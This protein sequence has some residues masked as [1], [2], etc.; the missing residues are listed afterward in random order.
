MAT[1]EFFHDGGD[2]KVTEAM[3]EAYN[4]DGFVIVRNLLNKT[5]VAKVREAVEGN[6]DLH[7]RA[8]SR[9]DG[10]NRRSKV[11]LWNHPGNDI[12]G[13]LARMERVAGTMEQLLDGE[14]Y[15]YHSK[16]MMKDA[17]TGG[18]H[19]W[20]QDYGYWYNNGCLYPDMGS[21]FIPIDDCT[22]ENSCLQVLKSSHHLGRINHVRVGEQLGAD[23]ERVEQAKKHLDHIYVEMTAGDA[24]FFHCNLLHTSDQ[25]HSSRRRWVFI[26]AFNKRSNNPYIEHHHPCYTPMVKVPDSALLECDKKESLEGKGFMK[27]K[28]DVS[29]REKVH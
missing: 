4:N 28:D 27:L 19:S 23:L 24:L 21:V 8:Y 2:W 12:T 13:M 15:H 16:L 9:D 1:T 14:V 7:S 5:E 26:V 25:N 3:K 10:K 6:T 22:R 11:V 18:R 29:I 17:H 20:H